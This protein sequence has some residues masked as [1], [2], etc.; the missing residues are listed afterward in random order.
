M[1]TADSFDDLPTVPPT[2]T[3]DQRLDRAPSPD[4]TRKP[5]QREPE[6]HVSRVRLTRGSARDKERG[7]VGYIRFLLNGWL[8]LD[9]LTLRRRAEGG[10]AISYPLRKRCGDQ[11]HHVVY[12][13]D[14]RA[15]GRLDALLLE[16]LQRKG[17][18][19]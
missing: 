8:Q 18:L 3:P 15:R 12:P 17:L 9:G 13:I 2:Y 7:L 1:A 6:L 14:E 5:A 16:A 11:E 19:S 4:T 10:H